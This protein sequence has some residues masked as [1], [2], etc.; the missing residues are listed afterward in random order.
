MCFSSFFRCLA[1]LLI[2]DPHSAAPLAI[3]SSSDAKAGG[4]QRGHPSPPPASGQAHSHSLC[5]GEEGY[6][7]PRPTR[8]VCYVQGVMGKRVA[9]GGELAI[10]QRKWE[11][12]RQ[13]ASSPGGA[14]PPRLDEACAPAPPVHALGASHRLGQVFMVRRSVPYHAFMPR[15]SASASP[16]CSCSRAG[17]FLWGRLAPTGRDGGLRTATPCTLRTLDSSP[18]RHPHHLFGSVPSARAR[19]GHGGSLP[20][21]MERCSQELLCRRGEHPGMA[22]PLLSC[23]CVRPSLAGAERE[24]DEAGAGTVH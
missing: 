6:S 13:R 3:H 11:G 8:P 12:E 18:P 16:P 17:A 1:H 2:S 19:C 22:V 7:P 14:P 21:G 10:H 5:Q 4:T 24:P 23:A 15:R 20:A 9:G